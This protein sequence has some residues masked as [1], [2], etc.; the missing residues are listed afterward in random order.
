MAGL[1][2]SPRRNIPKDGAGKIQ[3]TVYFLCAFSLLSFVLASVV[4]FKQGEKIKKE[5][6]RAAE[7]M[8]EALAAFRECRGEKGV[9]IDKENDFNETGLIGVKFSPTTTSLGSLEA[10]STAA[11]PNFAALIVYLLNRAGVRKGNIVTAGASG[12]FPSLIVAALSAS[13]AM[14]LKLL[15]ISSLGAS[16][17]GANNPDF[18]WLDMQ[19]CLQ[20]AGLFGAQPIA[21]SLGGEKDTGMDMSPEGRA[22]L[23]QEAEEWGGMFLEEPDLSRNVQQRMRLYEKYAGEEEIK[24]FINIGGSWSN[25]GTDSEVLKLKPGLARLRYI[26]PAEERGVMQEMALRR[27]PVVHLLH[28]KGLS[29][30]YRL[31]WDPKPLPH[32]GEGRLFH[33]ASETQP[34]FFCIAGGYF[35][36]LILVIVFRK[37]I[38]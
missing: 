24:A 14:D 11:N 4:P 18:H 32:P 31:P 34:S 33:L 1:F 28:I 10:K 37:K 8:E 19:S 7:I 13:K 3:R 21:I 6:I 2:F 15:L 12:S 9:T 25:L 22:I 29:C 36:L 30:R 5:M 38:S 26:P 23:L 27:I 35:I 16:Q 20:E 17:W